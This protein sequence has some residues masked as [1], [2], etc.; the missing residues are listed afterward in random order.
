MSDMFL[1]TCL[2]NTRHCYES[3]ILP[4]MCAKCGSESLLVE[5]KRAECKESPDRTASH[6]RPAG[7]GS[8]TGT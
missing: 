1:I 2:H 7:S 8:S 5:V 4:Q 3:P 6:Q